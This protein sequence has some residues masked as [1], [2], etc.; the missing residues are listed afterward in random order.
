MGVDAEN[1]LAAYSWLPIRWQLPAPWLLPALR[2]VPVG[3]GLEAGTKSHT[4]HLLSA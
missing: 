4:I 2:G 3:S 1:G